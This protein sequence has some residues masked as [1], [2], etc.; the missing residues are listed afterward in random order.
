MRLR[1]AIPTPRTDAYEE[2]YNSWRQYAQQYAHLP[3][4]LEQ[5]PLQDDP[6]GMMRRFER[7]L[8][9]C[10]RD[11]HLCVI[12]LVVVIFLFAILHT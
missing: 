3:E 7:E 8:T 1:E 5:C 11:K 12:F 10:T 2:V 6:I 4:A 9:I